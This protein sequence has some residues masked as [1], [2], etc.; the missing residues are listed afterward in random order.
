MYRCMGACSTYIMCIVCTDT[1]CVLSCSNKLMLA[2]SAE[3]M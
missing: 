2:S 3:G 1:H